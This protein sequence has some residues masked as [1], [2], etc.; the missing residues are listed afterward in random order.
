MAARLNPYITFTGNAREAMEFY[1]G[2]F[3]GALDV[4]TYGEMP[5]MPGNSPEI[6]DQLMH[7]VLEA[8]D[9]LTLMG[10]DMPSSP[11]PRGSAIS[12]AVSGDDEAQLR[13]WFDGLADGGE[14]QEQLAL[15]PWGTLF[16]MLVD[17]FGVHWMISGEASAA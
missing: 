14:I 10:A 5:D 1:Q 13:R 4:S 6:H 17:R 2:V 7:S 3:G 8:G 11:G 9:A 16:G 15:A 12:I